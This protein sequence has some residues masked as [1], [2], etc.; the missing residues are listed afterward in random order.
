MSLFRTTSTTL[1]TALVLTGSA[2]AAVIV[3]APIAITHF[4]EVQP[5]QVMQGS[6]EGGATATFFGNTTQQA[7]IELYIDT[8]WAQVGVDIRFLPPVTYVSSFAYNGS[9]TNYTSVPRPTNDLNVINS[10]AGSPPKSTNPAV[11]NM[12]FVDIVPGFTFTTE[13]TANGLAYVDGNGVTQFVGDNLLTFTAGREVIGIVVAHEIGHNLGLPH[14]VEAENLMQE[15][16]APN[17]G[18]RLS[19]AQRGLILTDNPGADG[20]ALLQPIPEPGSLL[21]TLLALTGLLARRRRS[22]ALP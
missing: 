1:V 12:F 10:S 11:L 5:I 15:G 20:F 19:S 6:A 9:P 18:A 7:A 3:N 14:L 17:P 16:G 22:P 2:S 13:N 4:V 8:I 21:T